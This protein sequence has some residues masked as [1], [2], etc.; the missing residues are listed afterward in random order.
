MMQ[1]HGPTNSG[2]FGQGLDGSRPNISK[3]YDL[4]LKSPAVPTNN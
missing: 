1:R 4:Y 2:S 3:Q